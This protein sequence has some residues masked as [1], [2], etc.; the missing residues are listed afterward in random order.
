MKLFQTSSEII[1]ISII[2][3]SEITTDNNCFSGLDFHLV[4]PYMMVDDFVPLM[5]RGYLEEYAPPSF[6]PPKIRKEFPETW[7]WESAI[8]TG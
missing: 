6:Q 5:A 2:R 4:G 8:D 1:I 3:V 7:L